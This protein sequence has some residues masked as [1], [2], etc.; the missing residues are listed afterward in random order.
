VSAI[1][2]VMKAYTSKHDLNAEQ[3]VRVRLELANFIDEL[4][5][6]ARREPTMFPEKGCG[7]LPVLG[8][9]PSS[10]DPRHARARNS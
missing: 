5:S 9:T 7:T 4:M 1:E 3:A 8:D 6:M 10:Q 2:R